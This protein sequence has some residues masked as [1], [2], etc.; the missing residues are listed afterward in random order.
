[1]SSIYLFTALE[2]PSSTSLMNKH[3]ITGASGADG[4]SLKDKNDEKR[5]QRF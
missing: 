4:K 3:V 1:M 5:A 2:R